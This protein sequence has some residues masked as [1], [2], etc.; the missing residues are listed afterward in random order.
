MRIII[1]SALF[2]CMLWMVMFSMGII[3]EGSLAT[4]QFRILV[5][6]AVMGLVY[7]LYVVLYE[8]YCYRPG[9]Q[10]RH[11]LRA[12]FILFEIFVVLEL[13]FEGVF[14]PSIFW[15]R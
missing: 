6:L 11:G 1:G 3:P 9:W 4:G 15:A 12:F 8:W 10:K 7:S 5:Q 14:A 2:W 13:V